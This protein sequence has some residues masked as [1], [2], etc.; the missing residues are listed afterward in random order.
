MVPIKHN[1]QQIKNDVSYQLNFG[2]TC[3]QKNKKFGV[4]LCS[5]IHNLFQILG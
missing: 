4:H 5:V 2:L 1:D 3:N